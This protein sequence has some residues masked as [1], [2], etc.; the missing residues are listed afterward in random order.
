MVRI[1][2]S[3]RL[4]YMPSFL[5]TRAI[6]AKMR[7]MGKTIE[8]VSE[9]DLDELRSRI[10]S[11]QSETP[12]VTI[13]LIARNEE[14]N[15]LSTLDSLSSIKSMYPLEIVV[16]DNNSEDLTPQTIQACG[17]HSFHLE[18]LGA[19][20]ARQK[21]LDVCRG[22]Y[23]ICGDADTLYQAGWVDMLIGP[24][25][26]E[27]GI[28]CT[29][30]LHAPLTEDGR[31]PINLLLYT[32]AKYISVILKSFKRPHNV[33]GGAGMAFRKNDALSVGGF[34]LSKTRGSDGTMAFD[35][36][37]LGRIKLIHSSK[38]MIWTSIRR[39]L[40]DDSL[41]KAFVRRFRGIMSTDL[42]FRQYEK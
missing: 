38:A 39:T 41:L 20:H 4:I 14:R 26:R 33:I 17:A 21:S 15:I 35:L 11:L 42:I 8:E 24:L 32:W 23:L 3:P 2:F 27:S 19:C 12:L 31:V 18:K 5:P 30:G 13:A 16:I 6:R 1:S 29:S 37:K 7:F 40:K 34:D 36:S 22:T 25:E 10:E 9:N 28:I